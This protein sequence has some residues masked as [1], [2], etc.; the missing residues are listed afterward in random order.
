MEL[1]MTIGTGG[2]R[3]LEY[4]QGEQRVDNGVTFS[5]EWCDG[6]HMSKGIPVTPNPEDKAEVYEWRICGD[7]LAAFKQKKGPCD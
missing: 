2:M 4:Q 7:C 1:K 5:R 3:G 6:C